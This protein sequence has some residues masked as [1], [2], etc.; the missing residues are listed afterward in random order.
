[1][2]KIDKKMRYQYERV[3]KYT[4]Y[5]LIIVFINPYIVHWHVADV[6]KQTASSTHSTKENNTSFISYF[7]FFVL[8]FLFV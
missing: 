1:M 2:N 4:I 8:L 7:S 3:I 6:Q 5:K